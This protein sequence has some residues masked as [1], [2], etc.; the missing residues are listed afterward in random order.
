MADGSMKNAPFLE[1][2]LSNVHAGLLPI[3][4]TVTLL[5][6]DPKEYESKK[7]Y[8]QGCLT[9]SLSYREA[10]NKPHV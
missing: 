6:K 1:D 4:L 3:I 9:H 5:G 8:S 2:D 10:R 7:L